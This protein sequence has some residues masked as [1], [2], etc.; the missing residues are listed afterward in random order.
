MESIKR[1]KA[2]IDT[3]RRLEIIERLQATFALGLA[4]DSQRRIEIVNDLVGR[5]EVAAE[6]AR[7]PLTKSVI[8]LK[9]DEVAILL[10]TFYTMNADLHE[11]HTELEFYQQDA[12]KRDEEV[13][14]YGR[15][16][17]KYRDKFR[18]LN[19]SV[20]LQD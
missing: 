7:K 16:L 12:H 4:E 1:A 15:I 8:T 2:G 17:Q 19:W 13:E 6:D 20:R 14:E 5:L 10:R 3:K 18:D 9:P 11:N